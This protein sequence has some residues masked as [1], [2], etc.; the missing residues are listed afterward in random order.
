MLG[1]LNLDWL[2]VAFRTPTFGTARMI[3][4]P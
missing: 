2:G 4:R 3:T 1:T